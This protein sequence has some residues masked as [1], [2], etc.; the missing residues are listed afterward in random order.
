MNLAVAGDTESPEAT[1][2]LRCLESQPQDTAGQLLAHFGRRPCKDNQRL[3]FLH[4]PRR[5]TPSSNHQGLSEAARQARANPQMANLQAVELTLNTDHQ[6]FTTL[7]THI[8]IGWTPRRRSFCRSLALT[9][10]TLYSH[11]GWRR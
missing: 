8:W 9:K 3:Q 5:W 7:A 11:T 10:M 2:T 1:T 4:P 6:A